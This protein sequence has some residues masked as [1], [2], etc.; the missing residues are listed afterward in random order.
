[1]TKQFTDCIIHQCFF[2]LRESFVEYLLYFL[3]AAAQL[4]SGCIMYLSEAG[5]GEG[6]EGGNVARGWGKVMDDSPTGP[7]TLL[8]SFSSLSS[9]LDLTISHYQRTS[10]LYIL[11]LCW[12]SMFVYQESFLL[13]ISIDFLL[14][15]LCY[16]IERFLYYREWGDWDRCRAEKRSSNGKNHVLY[17][18]TEWSP[19]TNILV[20]LG[21]LSNSH[22]Y[23]IWNWWRKKIASTSALQGE[24]LGQNC[25]T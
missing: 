18:L 3:W 20:Q 21:N 23:W 24:D 19:T 4:I 13:D 5:W 22:Q 14:T 16:S 8:P 17:P 7:G 9:V 10:G 12:H 2:V 25:L 15:Y 6:R 11:R 1:M